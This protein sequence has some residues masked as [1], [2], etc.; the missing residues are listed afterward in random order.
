MISS[1]IPESNHTNETKKKNFFYEQLIEHKTVSHTATY[2]N[3]YACNCLSLTVL[4]FR[5]ILHFVS[6]V[7]RCVC[8]NCQFCFEYCQCANASIAQFTWHFTSMYRLLYCLQFYFHL[9]FAHT[10]ITHSIA[11]ASL[12]NVRMVT[13]SE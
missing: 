12:C 1:N 7:V 2:W 8:H 4:A 11:Y 9:F 13:F 6:C 5:F 10:Y 3:S